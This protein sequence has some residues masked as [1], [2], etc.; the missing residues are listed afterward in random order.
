MQELQEIKGPSSA[1]ITQQQRGPPISQ[2]EQVLMPPYCL[3]F[4][5]GEQR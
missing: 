1:G 5:A 3:I 4:T 2:Y